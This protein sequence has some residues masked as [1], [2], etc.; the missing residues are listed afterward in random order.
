MKKTTLFLYAL[1]LFVVCHSCSSQSPRRTNYYEDI[2]GEDNDTG[3]CDSPISSA[4]ESYE[5]GDLYTTDMYG[6]AWPS[7]EAIVADLT[8][9]TLSEGIENGYHEKDWAFKIEYGN[10]HDFEIAEEL[11]NNENQYQI[12][13]DMKISKGGNFYYRTKARIN[14]K[15]DTSGKPVLDYVSS[16]GMT[17]VSNGEFDDAIKPRID[18][19]GWGGTYCLFLRNT[20]ELTLV[21]GGRIRAD[22]GWKKFSSVVDPHKES[23]VGGL[24]GGGSVSDYVL[25][26]VVREL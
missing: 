5:Q 24:F 13:A 25:D 3:S 19:D 15:R 20:S 16:L 6:S 23:A 9:H 22:D 4:A 12:I 21:V 11:I 18:Q 26:F 1:F 14:Y 7:N 2:P 10:I 8:G 17:V